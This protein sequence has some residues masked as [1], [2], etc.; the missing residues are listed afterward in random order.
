MKKIINV[1]YGLG[2][3]V[4]IIGVMFKLL[5]FDNANEVL[6]CGLVTEAIVFAVMAFDFSGIDASKGSG[7]KWVIKKEKDES[8]K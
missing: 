1:F 6:L 8:Q 7:W 2:G 3:S 4:I 5:E